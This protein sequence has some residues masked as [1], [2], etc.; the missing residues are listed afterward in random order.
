[1]LTDSFAYSVIELNLLRFNV[2]I[3]IKIVEC[4]TILNIYF[5]LISQKLS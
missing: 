2:F 4:N 5:Y 3:K 1:M